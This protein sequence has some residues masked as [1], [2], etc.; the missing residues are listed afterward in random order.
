MKQLIKL[1]IGRAFHGRMFYISILIGSILS[2]LQIIFHVIP[3]SMEIDLYLTEKDLPLLYPGWL[4]SSWLGGNVFDIESFLFYLLLPILAV[5]PFGDSYFTDRKS[6][7]LKNV[8]I[9]TKKKNY[10]TAKGAAAFLSGGTAVV[11]PLLLN[12]ALAALFLPA[13]KPEPTAPYGSIAEES[14]WSELYYSSP[15][16]YVFAYLLIDFIFAGIFALIAL[17]ISQAA[18]YRFI[19]ILFPLFLYLFIYSIAK[20]LRTYAFAPTYFLNPGFGCGNSFSIILGE[21]AALAGLGLGTFW[22]GGRQ[23]TY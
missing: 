23:E 3:D 18:D 20:L 2:L 19:V 21:G 6:G 16:A 1:E 10:L 14:M 15:W 4:F 7:Y 8:Y 9:R 17:G 13:L 12:L 5:L 11:I 22:I